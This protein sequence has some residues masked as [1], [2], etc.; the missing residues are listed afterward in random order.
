[1]VERLH[2]NISR[3]II[4]N[5]L[6]GP[7]LDYT[8]NLYHMDVQD[9]CCYLSNGTDFRMLR[10]KHAT[11]TELNVTNGTEVLL[12]KHHAGKG[13]FMCQLWGLRKLHC[14]N[15]HKHETTHSRGNDW[16]KQFALPTIP[17]LKHLR[18]FSL[19]WSRK[20]KKHH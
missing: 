11:P 9:I 2:S 5:P 20:Y 6:C 13:G 17:T 4:D 19:W 14:S 1:M 16:R 8:S 10:R 18:H 15:E 3:A 7:L 12:H